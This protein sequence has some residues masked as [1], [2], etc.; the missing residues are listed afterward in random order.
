MAKVKTTTSLFELARQKKDPWARATQS[1]VHD[2]GLAVKSVHSFSFL[3]G[4]RTDEHSS[5]V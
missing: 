5:S 1:S 4:H 3:V 2:G